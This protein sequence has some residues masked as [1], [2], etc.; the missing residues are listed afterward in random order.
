MGD[1]KATDIAKSTA[2]AWFERVL[3]IGILANV[4]LAIPT[5]VWPDLVLAWMGLP[6][7]STLWVRFASLLLLLLSSFYV[8]AALDCQRARTNAWLATTSRLAGV[9][10]FFS[11]EQRYWLFAVYD[12]AF[13]VP[14]A[15]LLA[16]GASAPAREST[17]IVTAR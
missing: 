3:S 7:A 15:L 2:S 13:F 8:P 12:A 9:I 6:L 11:Q 1:T 14:L 17:A 10:F 4:A 5:L 16:L